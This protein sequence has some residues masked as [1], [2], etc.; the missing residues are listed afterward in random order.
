[1]AVI[2]AAITCG[3]VYVIKQHLDRKIMEIIATI[4][5]FIWHASPSWKERSMVWRARSVVQSGAI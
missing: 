5:A 1:M 3:M 2:S 4:P